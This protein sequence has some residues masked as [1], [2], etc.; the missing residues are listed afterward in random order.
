MYEQVVVSLDDPTIQVDIF[1][2]A[3]DALCQLSTKMCTDD[4]YAILPERK[5]VNHKGFHITRSPKVW[6]C[7]VGHALQTCIKA[8]LIKNLYLGYL[9]THQHRLLG[10]MHSLYEKGYGCSLCIHTG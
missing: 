6:I 3:C 5:A 10:F 7:S 8:E 2:P 9:E 1:Y 4:L